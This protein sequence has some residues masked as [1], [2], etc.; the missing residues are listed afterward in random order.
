MITNRSLVNSAYLAVLLI[1]FPLVDFTSHSTYFTYSSFT[2]GS[3]VSLG[4]IR[5]I[6]N[7]LGRH[8]NLLSCRLG[9]ASAVSFVVHF[10]LILELSPSNCPA[11]TRSLSVDSGPLLQG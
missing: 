3:R 10:I 4:Y 1:Q 9:K 11:L 6:C 2:S 8:L 5:L 7:T